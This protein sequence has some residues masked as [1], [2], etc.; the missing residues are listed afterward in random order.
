MEIKV[1]GD[2]EQTLQAI[3]EAAKNARRIFIGVAYI[4]RSGLDFLL[5]YLNTDDGR[6][7]I[8]LCGIGDMN[9]HDPA[10]LQQLHELSIAKKI[11]FAIVPDSAGIFHPKFYFFDNGSTTDIFIGSPNLTGRAFSNN[12][13]CLVRV[14]VNS[15]HTFARD[16]V[17]LF[18]QW[19][20]HSKNPKIPVTQLV[21]FTERL[22]EAE[23]SRELYRAAWL[24]C[25][26]G[27]GPAS[28]VSFDL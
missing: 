9:A 7:V 10:A 23:L 26:N 6:K 15:S 27:H 13:E 11:Q 8:F 22:K 21:Q 1:I 14:S 5:P 24:C 3:K 25:M 17:K 4:T 2:G 18:S 16:C 28:V 20:A 19:K 12:I